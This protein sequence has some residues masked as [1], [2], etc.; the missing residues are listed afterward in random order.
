M[1]LLW[2]LRKWYFKKFVSPLKLDI[3]VISI[4]N[5]S[6][7]GVG[8]TP[9]VA[10]FADQLILKGLRV[11][12]V[13][14]SY[15]ASASRPLEVVGDSFNDIQVC[16]DEAVLL[17]M[18]CP[19][20]KVFTGPVKWKTAKYAVQHQELDV[21][22]MDDGFQHWRLARDVDVVLVDAS[23]PLRKMK[24]FPFGYLREPVRALD[25]AHIK[26]LTKCE[27]ASEETLREY[28][29]LIRPE[30]EVSF[31]FAVAPAQSS[32]VSLATRA[33]AFCGIANSEHFFAEVK[34]HAQIVASHV[35]SDHHRYSQ[36]DF[37]LLT[38]SLAQNKA[39]IF[40]TTSKDAIKISSQIKPLSVLEMQVSEGSSGKM[41]LEQLVAAVHDRRL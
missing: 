35:F 30:G 13:T 36:E 2:L 14:K 26:I 28:R 24:L 20:A 3:P 7:G 33:V 4:G 21:L 34:K 25:R 18:K 40:L 19:A 37:D 12:I 23:M 39:N 8:K 17:K 10:Y 29:D 5:L 9:I 6:L 41:S 11:G 31:T 32:L 27:S 16:G 1:Y 22:I 15:K 38:Q